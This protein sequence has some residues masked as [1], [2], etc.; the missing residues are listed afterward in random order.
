MKRKNKLHIVSVLALGIFCIL[1]AGSME[2]TPS[3]TPAASEPSSSAPDSADVLN[4]AKALDDKYDISAVVACASGA[5]DYLRSIAKYDYKW[6]DTGMFETKFD[7]YLSR[8]ASPGVLTMI[9]G[10]AKL[11]NGFGAYQH[12]VLRCNYDTQNKSVLSYAFVGG[13]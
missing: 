9:S 5:D 7:S 1:A 6:D 2:D 3:S 12:I 13:R 11:Q 10:K 4:D 8:V